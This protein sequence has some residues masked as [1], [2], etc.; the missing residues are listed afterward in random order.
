MAA[1]DPAFLPLAACLIALGVDRILGEPRLHPLVAFGSF[2]GMVEKRL[3]NRV[4]RDRGTLGV[5][6]VVLPIVA[7]VWTCLLY[8]SDAADE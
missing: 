6:I 3:N 1:L 4:S 2:A 5:L 7:L 8:T